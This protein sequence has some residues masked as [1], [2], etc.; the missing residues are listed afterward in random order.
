MLSGQ[1]KGGSMSFLHGLAGT[2]PKFFDVPKT[3]N[4]ILSLSQWN[5]RNLA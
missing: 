3:Q 4:N 5:W 2:V 1:K